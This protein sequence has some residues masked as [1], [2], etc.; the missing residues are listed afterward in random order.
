MSKVNL[1]YNSIA[2]D[3]LAQW[4]IRRSRTLM[5]LVMFTVYVIQSK[6]TGKKY[7]G[8][9]SNLDQRLKRHDGILATK[10]TSYTQKN[11]GPWEVVYTEKYDTRQGALRRE[12]YLKSH[13]GREWLKNKLAR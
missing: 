4:Q 2:H 13:A 6:Y 5:R 1:D 8:E 3:P 12:K 11:K 9:T 7:I 10:S